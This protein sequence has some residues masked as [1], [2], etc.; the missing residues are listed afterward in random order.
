MNSKQNTG[1]ITL[2]M[3]KG[4]NI[5]S[6]YCRKLMNHCLSCIPNELFLNLSILH[7]VYGDQVPYK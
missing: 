6:K 1:K 7:I 4:K 3:I 5:I 2:G